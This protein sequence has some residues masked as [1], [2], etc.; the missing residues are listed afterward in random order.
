MIWECIDHGDMSTSGNS[1]LLPSSFIT[2]CILFTAWSGYI[3]PT[4]SY[5]EVTH[6]DM[7][8]DVEVLIVD[9][10]GVKVAYAD[11][12]WLHKYIQ[13]NSLQN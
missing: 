11:L 13:D 2:K 3:G 10:N 9:V 8:H 1:S 6:A 4:I 5:G 7:Y 12:S